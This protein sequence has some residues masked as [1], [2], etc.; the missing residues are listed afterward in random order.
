MPYEPF[1]ARDATD[2]RDD[3]WRGLSPKHCPAAAG[4]GEEV[5][6][7]KISTVLLDLLQAQYRQE[8]ANSLRYFARASWARFRG[9]EATADFF[10]REAEGERKHA[11]IVRGWIEDRNE[12]LVPEPFAYDEPSTFAEYSKLF[13]SAMAIEV[14]TTESLST[15]YASALK[16]GDFLLAAMVVELLKKQVEEENLYQSILDRIASRG[17]DA[18]SDHDIDIWIGGRFSS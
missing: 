15:I 6:M 11:D 13:E 2:R 10:V 8:T 18:A 17:S 5:A 3:A 16:E 9:F 7:G 14:A 12:A 4:A 1:D